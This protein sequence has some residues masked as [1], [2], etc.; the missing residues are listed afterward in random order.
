MVA[1][2]PHRAACRSPDGTPGRPPL[3]P[4]Q[5]ER[6]E[7]PQPRAVRLVSESAR[8]DDPVRVTVA[9]VEVEG[10]IEE[11]EFS[12][13][14]G[15]VGPWPRLLTDLSVQRGAMASALL[16]L[17]NVSATNLTSCPL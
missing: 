9:G 13:L 6:E 11:V 5:F 17:V 3:E 10:R 7:E 15:R 14:R 1:I 16:G 4:V 12:I 8:V 2:R